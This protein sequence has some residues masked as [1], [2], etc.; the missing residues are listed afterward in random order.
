M[1]SVTRRRALPALAFAV[2]LLAS[3]LLAGRA[4]AYVFWGFSAPASY[5]SGIGRALQSGSGV[6]GNAISIPGG[7]VLKYTYNPIRELGGD[8][9]VVMDGA[10]VYWGFDAPSSDGAGIG[11]AKI[12]GGGVSSQFVSIPGGYQLE[13]VAI[14]GNYIY[15]AWNAPTSDSA[16][17]GRAEL[18]GSHADDRYV[19]VPSGDDVDGLAADGSDI[20]WAWIAPTSDQSG[21]GRVALNGSHLS[22]GFI[23]LTSRDKPS[24]LAVNGSYI[25]FAW[26]QAATDTTGIG[27]ADLNGTHLSNSFIS[28]SGSTVPVG[29]G[30]DSS[31]IY[32]G[33][34]GPSN[35][36]A[37]VGRAKLNG[38]AVKQSFIG[39]SY[40]HQIGGI[41]VGGPPENTSIPTISGIIRQNHTLTE[42]HGSWLNSVS[43]Y[44]YR[45]QRCNSTGGGCVSISGATHGTYEL[46]SA[47]V[48]HTIRVQETASNASGAGKTATSAH[49]GKILPLPPTDVD[50]PTIS[51]NVSSV[52][53]VGLGLT[54]AHGVWNG[55]PTSYTYQWELCNSAG[56]SC[57]AIAGATAQTFTLTSADV[58][59]TLRVQ[60]TAKN[61]GGSSQPATSV[62]TPLVLPLPPV[63]VTVPSI[64]GDLYVTAS[65]GQTLSAV[66]GT[67]TNDPTSV[68]YQWILCSVGGSNCEA[69]QGA[70]GSTYTL[71]AGQQ[72][73]AIELQETATNSGGTSL[74]ATS[75]VSGEIGTFSPEVGPY[76]PT[77]SLAPVITGT[78]TPGQT[79]TASS[80]AWEGTPALTYT[81]TWQVCTSPTAC[82]LLTPD[83]TT[84][85]SATY[86]IPSSEGGDTIEVYVGATNSVVFSGS[87]AVGS[88]IVTVN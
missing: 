39:V 15:W 41:A 32:W 54:E 38:S 85:T 53:T 86:T 71:I 50:P 2:A 52:F 18:N 77:N 80:G 36:T 82:T 59:G 83:T 87:N 45:W 66:P 74:A 88:E 37:G 33:W 27:R 47:D 84:A 79:L 56:A 10:Y 49:T 73:D 76:A 1:Q 64:A 72:G 6:S 81:Y 22:N 8:T 19:T 44:S 13:G 78:A 21:I 31:Y 55:S 23:S 70:T 65:A 68:S 62:Q 5:Q 58:G 40:A 17:I 69:I 57:T 3:A 35:A 14:S 61:A 12:G 4:Q 28:L 46:R 60:E 29:V 11:R 24:G 30:L 63:N 51:A 7:D 16:G 26:Q 48:G 75:H 67:W 9:G 20:Y 34:T 43:S 25:Y 42:H